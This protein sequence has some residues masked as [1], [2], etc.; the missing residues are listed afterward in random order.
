MLENLKTI[1][2]K[3]V[4]CRKSLVLIEISN[5]LR[6]VVAMK[7]FFMQI[8]ALGGVFRPIYCLDF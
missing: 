4:F 2:K 7:C 6:E 8:G 3:C 5:S 1:L